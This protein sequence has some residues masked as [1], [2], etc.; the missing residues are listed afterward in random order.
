MSK[1]IL[2]LPFGLGDHI[3][4]NAIV[5]HYCQKYEKVA[6]FCLPQ[7]YPTVAFMFRDLQNLVIIA[8][9]KSFAKRFIATHSGDNGDREYDEAKIIG[10]ENFNRQSGELFQH[11]LYRLAGVDFDL[12]E[13]NFLVERDRGREEVLFAKIAPS[14][15]YI[16]L[17]EDRSRN[18]TIKRQKINLKYKVVEPDPTLTDNIFDYCTLLERAKEIHVIDSSFMF[19]VDCLPYQN[20]QQKLY[21]HR[22]ARPNEDWKLPVLKKDWQIITVGYSRLEKF[23]FASWFWGRK[24]MRKFFSL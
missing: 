15:S 20:S 6:T 10:F 17:H 21:V 11:Q 8:G 16:F 14:G 9:D 4:C 1:I 18:Y 22:Y 19:L 7:N 5:R 2:L 23:Y 24:I 13:K 3:Y 12:L